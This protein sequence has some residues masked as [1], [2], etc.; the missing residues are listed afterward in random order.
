[1]A[2]QNPD[3]PADQREK[4]LLRIVYLSSAVRALSPSEMASLESVSRRRNSMAG[5]TGLL[6]TQ[7]PHYFGVLEGVEPRLLARM[8][9]IATD[10]RHR[11]L[12]ILREQSI[13]SRR[14]VGWRL[15]CLP[16]VT[17]HDEAVP[18]V[19]FMLDFARRLA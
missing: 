2:Q 15:F 9:V 6:I 19:D 5:I 7:G 16:P 11:Q 8:E 14:F 17:R 10:P 1:V 13:A 4:S 3:Q 12:R 18:H